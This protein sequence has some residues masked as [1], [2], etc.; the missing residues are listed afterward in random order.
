[1]AKSRRA[2]GTIW[3]K[4]S[5]YDAYLFASLGLI[6]QKKR[7]KGRYLVVQ[8]GPSDA[9]VFEKE[10]RIPFPEWTPKTRKT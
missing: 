4:L 5:A 7:K 10:K 8:F 9:R 1:M 2:A 3:R 6:V